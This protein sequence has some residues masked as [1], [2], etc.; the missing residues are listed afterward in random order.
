MMAWGN[1]VV[2]PGGNLT[3]HDMHILGVAG[4]NIRAQ[5]DAA[6]ITFRNVSMDLS[7]DYSFTS[8]AIKFKEDVIISGTNTFGYSPTNISS[9]IDSYSTLHLDTGITFN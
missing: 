1:L 4:N 9:G 5:G 2:A 6:S 8:G 7:S 3:L